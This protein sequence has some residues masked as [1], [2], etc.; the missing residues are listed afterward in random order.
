MGLIMR[1]KVLLTTTLLLFVCGV[2]SK[3]FRTKQ[4]PLETNSNS[5]QS[6][7][8]DSL[9]PSGRSRPGPLDRPSNTPA[10]D[11][12]VWLQPGQDW[13]A[14]VGKPVDYDED[15]FSYVP[16]VGFGLPWDSFDNCVKINAL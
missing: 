10:I 2:T 14:I 6:I 3:P 9:S 13:D 12:I 16:N 11:G 5:T 15:I 8:S 7:D 1:I 4:S